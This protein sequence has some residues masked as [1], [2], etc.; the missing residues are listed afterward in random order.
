MVC[1]TPGPWLAVCSGD[2]APSPDAARLLSRAL[3]A[4]AIWF[5]LA[6][7]ALAYHLVQYDLGRQ[8]R[9]TLQP[10]EIFSTEGGTAL[11]PEYHDVEQELHGILLE[12]GIPSDYAYLFFREI[13]IEGGKAGSPDAL[14]VRNGV[15]EAF[16]HR[17]P[18]RP[19]GE[20]RTLFDDYREAEQTVGDTIRL[21]GS[22]DAARG[23]NLLRTL[24]RIIR[25]RSLPPGWKTQ[26]LL[27][28][29]EGPD[30]ALRLK[31][32]HAGKYSYDLDV[33]PS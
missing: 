8:V 17:V 7:N 12:K 2:D 26:V 13:G 29:A 15:T 24:D 23:D 16:V 30:L 31:R 28:P 3:E 33:A 14:I 32:A 1:R 5:G 4:P 10:P 25:R 9:Q 27:L 21:Q 18:S 6:G 20:V 19:A 11:L 22:Y